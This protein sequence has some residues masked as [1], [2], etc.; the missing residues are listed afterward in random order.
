MEV[1][2][3]DGSSQIK[4]NFIISKLKAVY[5]IPTSI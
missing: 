5:Q 4:E 2:V 1:D 3:K